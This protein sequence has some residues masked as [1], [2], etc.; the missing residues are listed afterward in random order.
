[1][2]M[3]KILFLDIDGVLNSDSTKERFLQFT[4]ISIFLATKLCRWLEKRKEVGVVLSSTWRLEDAFRNHVKLQGIDFVDCTPDLRSAGLKRGF[5][6][7]MWLK[8]HPNVTTYGILDDYDPSMFLAQQ[9]PWL[10]QT[11]P[12]FG[13][14]DRNLAKLDDLMGLKDGTSGNMLGP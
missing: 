14:R 11:S 12:I 3:N 13:L 2:T 10:V 4:G 6:I 9:R 8:D 1:M 5:E 7:E